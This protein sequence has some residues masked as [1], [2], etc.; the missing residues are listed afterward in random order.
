MPQIALSTV[1]IR[2][3]RL[4]LRPAGSSALTW[5]WARGWQVVA[6]GS[7]VKVVSEASWAWRLVLH[8][9]QGEVGPKD[10][11]SRILATVS[12]S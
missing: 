9:V 4:R 3:R 1:T 5:L 7:V 2:K 8:T 10:L 12:G 11:L 6:N